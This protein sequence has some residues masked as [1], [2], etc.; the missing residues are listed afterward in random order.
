MLYKLSRPPYVMRRASMYLLTI[1]AH[2]I[3]PGQLLFGRGLIDRILGRPVLGMRR[4]FG[5]QTRELASDTPP[6][7][8]P[9]SIPF[10]LFS[11]KSL[12]LSSNL[13]QAS[14]PSALQNYN[15]N[16][17]TMWPEVKRRSKDCKSYVHPINYGFV[18]TSRRLHGIH[19]WISSAI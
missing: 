14:P 11:H 19:I 1:A 7:S 9:P 6:D 18:S 13:S 12:V 15:Y 2:C 10:L 4:K 5:F 16:Y 3:L 17:V 8:R